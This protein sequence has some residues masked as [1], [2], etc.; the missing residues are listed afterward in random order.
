MATYRVVHFDAAHVASVTAAGMREISAVNPAADES[1]AWG[2]I[3]KLDHAATIL[4]N[5]VPIAC[6]G[7]IPLWPGRMSAWVIVREDVCRRAALY[8]HR[9]AMRLLDHAQENCS[10]RRIEAST[11]ASSK[12]SCR[13]LEMLGFVQEGRMAYYGPDGNDHLLYAR[14]RP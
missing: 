2:E 4:E 7:A 1:F 9:Q 11:S 5:G 12:E 13:W 8:I 14:I 10:A 3:A 6:G